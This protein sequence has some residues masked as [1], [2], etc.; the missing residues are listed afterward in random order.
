MLIK[1]LVDLKVFLRRSGHLAQAKR[2]AG[3][4]VNPATSPLPKPIAYRLRVLLERVT[5]ADCAQ[6][7]DLPPIF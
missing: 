1:L 3:Y 7:H 6:I 4:L 2:L 5:Y